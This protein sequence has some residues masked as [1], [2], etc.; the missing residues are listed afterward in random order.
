MSVEKITQTASIASPVGA[1]SKLTREL[2]VLFDIKLLYILNLSYP[3]QPAI[4]SKYGYTL[5]NK[6]T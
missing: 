3:A 6:K 2:A 4:Q 1:H 5:E